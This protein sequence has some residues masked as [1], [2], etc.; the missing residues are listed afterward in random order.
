MNWIDLDNINMLNRI[1]A[2]SMSGR[3]AI[4]KHSTRCGISRMVLKNFKSEAKALGMDIN[5]YLLD[6][7][8]HRN[9]S[10]AIAERWKVKHESPQLIVLQNGEVIH[11]ASHH[12]IH[13]SNLS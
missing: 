8:S 4:F 11:H 7:L 13:S 10:N 5:I 1:E 6:L 9:I 12:G 3:V 2:D